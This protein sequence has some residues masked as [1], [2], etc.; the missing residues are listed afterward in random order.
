[1][2]PPVIET[3]TLVCLWPVLA[4]M[5]TAGVEPNVVTY[6]ALI[7][8]CVN[9]GD[10]DGARQVLDEALESA[11]D[12]LDVT[13]ADATWYLAAGELD[14]AIEGYEKCYDTNRRNTIVMNNLAAAYMQ[15]GRTDEAVALWRR[16]LELEPSNAKARSN[17]RR[18]ESETAGTPSE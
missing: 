8:A 9:G 3:D 2:V 4:Q 1:M 7:S 12:N 10:M 11:P 17:L 14:K 13:F 16:I 15:T 18:H 5:M 6:T